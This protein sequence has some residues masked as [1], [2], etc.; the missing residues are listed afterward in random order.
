MR[1]HLVTIQSWAVIHPRSEW[2]VSFALPHGSEFVHGLAPEEV[3]PWTTFRDVPEDV[4]R[5]RQFPDLSWLSPEK[6]YADG[7]EPGAMNLIAEHV[8]RRHEKY[9][10]ES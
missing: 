2:V 9:H 8:Q 1:V 10:H 7:Q 4:P 5:V 3:P 6:Q